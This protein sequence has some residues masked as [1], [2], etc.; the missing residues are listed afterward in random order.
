[1]T[2]WDTK[3]REPYTAAGI[4]RVGCIRCGARAVY[5]WSI[6][7]DGNN[8]RPIC[9]PCDIALNRMV[10]EWFEHPETDRLMLAY[11]RK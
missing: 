10:L 8:H 1:M 7:A 5:Q 4:A 6:C 9:Q 2:S 11:E 3:R